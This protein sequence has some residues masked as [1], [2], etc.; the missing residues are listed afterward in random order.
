MSSSCAARSCSA[1]ICT[2]SSLMFFILVARCTACTAECCECGR[3]IPCAEGFF[4][5]HD[6]EARDDSSEM[7]EEGGLRHEEMDINQLRPGRV[8]HWHRDAEWALYHRVRRF[9]VREDDFEREEHAAETHGVR[10]RVHVGEGREEEEYDGECD[11]DE[12]RDEVGRGE[13]DYESCTS[14][15]S[16]NFGALVQQRCHIVADV[17]FIHMYDSRREQSRELQALNNLSRLQ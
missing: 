16:L 3:A 7:A 9:V 17:V 12:G 5:V 10:C 15:F 14:P 6:D 4:R 11:I 2:S 1:V 8:S 13:H